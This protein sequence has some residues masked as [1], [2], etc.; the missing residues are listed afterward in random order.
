MILP[1]LAVVVV[2]VVVSAPPAVRGKEHLFLGTLGS[3][4]SQRNTATECRSK[5]VSV[6]KQG[7]SSWSLATHKRPAA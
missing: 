2:V 7:F 5:F 3:K 4:R 1:I 6:L